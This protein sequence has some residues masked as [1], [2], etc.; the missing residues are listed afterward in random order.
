MFFLKFCAIVLC[1]LSSFAINLTHLNQWNYPLL[2]IGPVHCR[3][4]GRWVVFFKFIQ[5]LIEHS[6]SKQ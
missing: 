5:I 3:F 2:S 1:I 4:K 6:V